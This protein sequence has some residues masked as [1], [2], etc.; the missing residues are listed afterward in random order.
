MSGEQGLPAGGDPL[1]ELLEQQYLEEKRKAAAEAQRRHRERK[2]QE[3]QTAEAAALPPVPAY[4]PEALVAY[5]V[6]NPGQTFAQYGIAFGHN[7]AWF[8]QVLA[9]AAFQ[10][11]LGQARG[12]INDPAITG[13]LEDRFRAL[14]LQSLAVLQQKL[15]TPEVNDQTVLRAVELSFKALGM[16]KIEQGPPPAVENGAEAVADKIMKAME[17]AQSRS[18]AKA[19]VVEPVEQPSGQPSGGVLR[20]LEQLQQQQQRQQPQTATAA[21]PVQGADDGS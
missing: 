11:H 5:L 19:T 6:E 16:G 12:L 3:L 14:S 21:V 20:T 10:F 17:S 2:R 7:A 9:S 15:D 13:T 1:R 4:T 8:S 18:N